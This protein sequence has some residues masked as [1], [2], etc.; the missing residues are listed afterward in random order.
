MK[1][2]L[3]DIGRDNLNVGSD[4]QV[5]ENN[6]NI[7]K[8]IGCFQCWVKTPGRC[9]IMDGYED[10]GI[11]LSQCT[12]LVIVSESVYGSTS[13]FIKN[14]LDRAISYVHPNFCYRNGE[15]HHKRRYDNQIK[16][17]A[18]LYGENM[19]E[20]EKETTRKLITANAVNFDGTVGQVVFLNSKE[21][22]RGITL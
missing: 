12:D 11:K 9:V 18:Y 19:T 6:G 7:H 10:M 16:I 2:V 14:A 4:V 21:E 8:C 17:S 15:M 1:L 22:L 5:I 20:A 13:P 3:T